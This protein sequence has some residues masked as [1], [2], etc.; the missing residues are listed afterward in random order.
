MLPPIPET[1]QG[2]SLKEFNAR[3]KALLYNPTV[4]NCWVMAETSDLRVSRGHCY[5]ELIQKNEAG[6]TVAKCG[7]VIWASA[8][9][10]LNFRFKEVTGQDLASGMKVLVKVS[11]NYHELY[12]LKVLI[13]DINPQYTLGDMARLRAEIIK[14]LQTEGIYDLNRSLEIPLVP[15]R[16]AVVSAPGAAGYGDFMKQLHD[17]SHGLKFYTAL[18]A[19]TMQ[20]TQTAPTVIAALERIAA[21][22]SEFD[23]VVII[24]GGGS[25]SDLNSFD[26][27]DLAANV[28]QF[29][30]PVITGIG[31]DRD[32]TVLDYVAAWPV[33]TPTA[34]AQ[35]L[36]TR[37]TDALAQLEAF[38]GA[39]Q[40]TVQE[41]LS[42][43]NEQLAHYSSLIP[44]AATKLLETSRL[45]LAGFM[46]TIPLTVNR[47]LDGERITLKHLADN[48]TMAIP[49]I[50]ERERVKLVN[51]EEKVNI[52][53]PRNTLNRGYS[54]TMSGGR[55]ITDATQLQPGDTVTTHLRN[56][57]FR[58]TVANK[59]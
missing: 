59:Q 18:F 6:A 14:R 43:A 10:H 22:E 36:I 54:L 50:F 2:I 57:S 37:G 28:A 31:H 35:F 24:R 1:P 29:P 9:P 48:I 12:G 33:K 13:D 39:I 20:G 21:H 51:L 7:A 19:A 38:A 4:Q 25:T 27:Y 32:T 53:S 46:Q 47:R 40:Q 56:G 5:L 8:F 11:A 16:I 49:Q 44:L 17:N 3:M 42:R 23:C 15:Q 41:S 30:L 34:A 26:N 52:L 55:I 45:R 58:S